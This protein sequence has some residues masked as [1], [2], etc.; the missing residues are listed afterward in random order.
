MWASGHVEQQQESPLQQVWE[1]LT[2]ALGYQTPLDPHLALALLLSAAGVGGSKGQG[3]AAAQPE[4]V[5]V[6]RGAGDVSGRSA[7]CQ[8][9]T[10]PLA[11]LLACQ[12]NVLVL[13]QAFAPA[14]P[15]LLRE[16]AALL[17]PHSVSMSMQH[18]QLVV[19]ITAG[20]SS[21]GSGS[22]EAAAK[23]VFSSTLLSANTGGCAGVPGALGPG[24]APCAPPP[25]PDT[26]I[27]RLPS[28]LLP[29]AWR[30]Q[31]CALCQP[32][33][34]SSCCRRCSSAP[35][36]PPR[37]RPQASACPRSAP[38]AGRPRRGRRCAAL[39]AAAG[40]QEDAA[41]RGRRA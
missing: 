39:T 21:S 25:H 27:A 23:A 10:P 1:L 35:H 12:V 3:G 2:H 9:T 14:T 4:Q 24:A 6:C 8:P 29:Q 34:A 15:R 28:P 41:R 17:S 38:R 32:R 20:S 30:R 7:A 33:P 22:N 36:P 11:L 5:C 40:R 19:P 31:S 37:T 16:A 26:L 13:H 18:A